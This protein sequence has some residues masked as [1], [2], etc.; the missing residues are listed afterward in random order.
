MHT[1]RT[2]SDHPVNSQSARVASPTSWMPSMGSTCRV[3][4]RSSSRRPSSASPRRAAP[5]SAGRAVGGLQRDL[6]RRP[7]IRLL[8]SE[9]TRATS[10]HRHASCCRRRAP[11]GQERGNGPSTR[12]GRPAGRAGVDRG[13]DYSEHALTSGSGASAVAYVEAEGPTAPLWGVAWT[14]RSRRLALRGGLGRNRQLR[15]ECCGTPPRRRG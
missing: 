9:I 11:H 7:G 10:G 13:E 8:S 3:D 5:R 2:T 6:P 15:S 14:R 4:C 12:C 1:G